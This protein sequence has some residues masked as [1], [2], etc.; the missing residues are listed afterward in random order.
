[1][2]RIFNAT[3][4]CG[5]TFPVDYG[6]R[7]LDDVELECPYCHKQFLISEAAKLDERWTT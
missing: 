5:S 3:C 7:F 2:Q 6:I 1:M 4:P